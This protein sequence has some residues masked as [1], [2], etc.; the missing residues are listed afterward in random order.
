MAR[1]STFWYFKEKKGDKNKI[2]GKMTNV[3]KF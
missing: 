1:K 2:F 3:A